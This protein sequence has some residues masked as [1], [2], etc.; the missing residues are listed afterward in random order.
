MSERLKLAEYFVNNYQ[1]AAVDELQQMPAT[2]AGELIETLDDEL[3]ASVLHFN[4]AHRCGTMH[5]IGTEKVS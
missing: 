3:S 5:R 4:A 1:A 2:A